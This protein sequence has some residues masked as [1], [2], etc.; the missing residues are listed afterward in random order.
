M[1][2]QQSQLLY[3]SKCQYLLSCKKI[4]IQTL[5]CSTI[6]DTDPSFL[7]QP[8]QNWMIIGHP[9][10]SFWIYYEHLFWKIYFFYH[11]QCHY[12]APFVSWMEKYSFCSLASDVLSLTGTLTLSLHVPWHSLF[13]SFQ[14]SRISWVHISGCFNANLAMFL[15]CALSIDIFPLV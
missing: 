8:F 11:F 1:L 13:T 14:I 4:M 15:F 12:L 6:W 9:W 7:I 5:K 2:M 10:M 3:L